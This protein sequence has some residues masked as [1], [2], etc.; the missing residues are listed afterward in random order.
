M[1]QAALLKEVSSLKS[2]L[3]KCKL[4]DHLSWNVQNGIPAPAG[5]GLMTFKC[6]PTVRFL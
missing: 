3:L 2:D 5:V 1:E 6:L 4:D